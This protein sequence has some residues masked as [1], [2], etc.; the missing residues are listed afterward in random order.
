MSCSFKKI[1]VKVG[2][3]VLAN[4]DGSLDLQAMEAIVRQLANLKQQGIQ[5]V[6]VSSGAVGAGRSLVQL[7]ANI[8]RVVRRQVL[9]S[10]GQVKLMNLYAE[11]FGVSGLHCAQVLAT[12]ED[13]RDRQHYINMK[14][15]LLALQRNNLIP[16]VNENDVVAISELMFTDNGELAALVAAMVN[17]EA[18]IILSSVDGVLDGPPTD[19]NSRVI[20]VI[21][22]STGD[23]SPVITAERSSF[24]RGG[25]QTKFRMAQRAAQVGITT[26]IANGK[27]SDIL[28]D[29]LSGNGLCT[30]F[31]PSA[32]GLSNLKKW[33]A[34]SDAE[35]KGSVQI[36]AGAKEALQHKERISS[37]LP[38]GVTG[39]EGDFER[40]DMIQVLDENGVI[41][42]LGLAQYGAE[43]A[44]QWMGQKGKKPLIHY[45]YMV[46]TG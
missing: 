6:L 25:M 33:I 13:F 16:I 29:I 26:F 32:Q 31:E 19:P 42:A 15:C 11:Q 3:Q 40:G 9:A 5:V 39:I 41:I 46:L 27:R 36:N 20:P 18:L 12:K 23:Y 28:L 37:L 30:R 2:T 10:V 35:H 24:G 1:V 34:Y 44:R 17:A 43:K 21:D 4:P 7:P 45:D 8:N 38:V 14:N 22:A